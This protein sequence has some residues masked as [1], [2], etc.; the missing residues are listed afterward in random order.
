M[1]LTA[2]AAMLSA[3]VASGCTVTTITAID[4]TR[5][6]AISFGSPVIEGCSADK[7]LS[8]ETLSFGLWNEAGSAGI[9]LR[10]A[11]Y[12][13]GNAECQVIVWADAG[14]DATAFRARFAD[15]EN[16]CVIERKR[17]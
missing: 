9:G 7:P 1:R 17:G 13:C 10:S 14:A 11:R 16:V 4:G 12:Y 15:I 5:M 6:Q 3:S 8:A 2:V